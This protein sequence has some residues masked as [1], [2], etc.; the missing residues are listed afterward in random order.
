[1]IMPASNLLTLLELD[2]FVAIDFETTGLD[3]QNCKIIELGA[4]RFWGGEPVE[5]FQQL[6]NPEELLSTEIIELTNI[7]DDMVMG[8]PT[9]DQVGQDF[10]DFVGTSPLVGQ[11]VRFD[12]SFMMGIYRALGQPETITNHLYDTMTLARTF[13]FHHTGFSLTALCDFFELEHEQAHRAYHDALNT[14]NI[15]VKLIHEAATCPLPVIQSLLG[16]QQHVD[17]PNKH[18]YVRLAN[19]MTSKGHLKGI[20]ESVID[21]PRPRAIYEH[22]G[23]GDDYGPVVPE[24]FFGKDGILSE[25]W[26]SYESRPIQVAFSEAVANTFEDGHILVAEAGTGLGKSLAYLLPAINAFNLFI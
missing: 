23:M 26:D 3:P 10:L 17:I 18:L 22:E 9:I 16:V 21:R 6:I 13:L 8:E 19:V 5:E 4:V 14:G 15:F 24:V 2:D 20:T 12:L 25:A 11:N 1:M 7:S